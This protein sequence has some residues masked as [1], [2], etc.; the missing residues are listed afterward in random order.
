MAKKIYVGVNGKARKVKKMYV[1]APTKRFNLGSLAE[2]D[3]V[4]VKEGG[5]LVE[6]YSAKHQY[7]TSLNGA[8]RTLLVRKD[9]YDKRKWHSSNVSA[10]ASSDIDSWLSST[11]KNTLDADIRALIGSTKIRYTPGHGNN[12]MGTLDR[13]VFLLSAYELGQVREYSN[14]EGEILPIAKTLQIAHL[15]DAPVDQWTR[16]P[17]TNTT[18]WPVCLR[19][20]GEASREDCYDALGARPVFTL[21][22]NTL[23][24]SDGVVLGQTG[25]AGTI[26]A[27]R[28]IKRG[29]IG[30]GGV[31]RPFWIG[32]KELV[33]YGPITAMST[34]RC[35]HAGGTVGN[36]ALFAGGQDANTYV[37]TVDTYNTALTRG[38][39]P[40]LN[41]AVWDHAA[42]SVGNY[43]IFAGGRN[44]YYQSTAT[45]Y[46]QSLTRSSP[47]SL[48]STKLGLTS[49][50]VGSYALFAGGSRGSG[51]LKTVD[52]YN[53]SLT[54]ST[55]TD[56]SVER[57]YGAA[58]GISGYAL[59]SG[60]RDA[61]YDDVSSVDAY[62]ASLTRSI[63]ASLSEKKNDHQGATVN[64]YAI[65]AGGESSAGLK[66]VDVFD[67]SLTRKTATPLS[68][69]MNNFASASIDDFAIFAG[70]SKANGAVNAYSKSLTRTTLTLHSGHANRYALSGA[71]V[72]GYALFSGGL[73]DGT[74]LDSVEAFT[75]L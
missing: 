67:T 11:Y 44:D 27:A 2:G 29:Y 37:A 35:G 54:R 3:T 12:T 65:F 75:A 8:G 68:V 47:S 57:Q 45:A 42:A 71:R 7:Q 62:N 53:T 14:N 28:K 40:N 63:V 20:N 52:A 32:E 16:S 17:A 4:K 34:V 50:S 60:G 18:G 41:E 66:T 43:V 30:I 33:S 6:F 58:A 10:Y 36:Y 51:P 55:V 31:A 19:S 48:S 46:N 22:T 24:D 21:P 25:S 1:G 13:A 23:L 49:A 70:G 69:G 64:G 74:E 38:S 59:F 5:K 26:Q 61:G 72:G 9:C 73:I 15:N 56:L 39:A